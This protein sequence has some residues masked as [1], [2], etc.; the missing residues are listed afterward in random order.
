MSRTDE[1]ASFDALAL[2]ELVRKKEVKAVELV[3]AAVEKIER[4][5]PNLNAVITPLFEQARRAAFQSL[6][7]P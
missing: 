3:D 2:A 7:T 6:R 5:N 4:L 1:Y